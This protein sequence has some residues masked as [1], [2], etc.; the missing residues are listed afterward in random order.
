LKGCSQTNNTLSVAEVFNESIIK[1]YPSFIDINSREATFNAEIY[2]VTG[3][4]IHQ[5]INAQKIDFQF[6][7]KEIYI[8]R[9]S[10]ENGSQFKIQKFV[11]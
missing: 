11:K 3:Q 6:L 8:L 5:F 1:I 7:T 4:L 2:G 9:L 10:S